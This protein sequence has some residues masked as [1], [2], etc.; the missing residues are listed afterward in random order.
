MRVS[1]LKISYL[2]VTYFSSLR[3]GFT[4]NVFPTRKAIITCC[5]KVPASQS[6]LRGSTWIGNKIKTTP[7]SF[8][9]KLPGQNIRNHPLTNS[10]GLPIPSCWSKD[11]HK[12]WVLRTPKKWAQSCGKAQ[13]K[14]SVYQSVVFTL[15]V[16]EPSRA[17]INAYFGFHLHVETTTFG[18]IR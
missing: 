15:P 3:K 8:D 10:E 4:K 1:V 11:V 2:W 13:V 18:A 14:S 12:C 5:E 16:L 17:F 6:H 9:K 7:W